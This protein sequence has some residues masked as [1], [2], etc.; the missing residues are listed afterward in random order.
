M[1]MSPN[2]DNM[3]QAKPRRYVVWP[4]LSDG[5]FTI[6]DTTGSSVSNWSSP[7]E[8]F[9]IVILFCRFTIKATEN[10]DRCSYANLWWNLIVATR[11]SSIRT[12]RK[13]SSLLLE[14]I[15]CE[16][17]LLNHT[18]LKTSSNQDYWNAFKSLQFSFFGEVFFLSY[19]GVG[20]GGR[21]NFETT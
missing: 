2:Q 10:V 13:R 1:L 18:I 14:I 9:S 12:I 3:V 15:I 17:F 7:S 4:L 21:L 8:M 20:W 16:L 6:H 5:L 11:R 19:R